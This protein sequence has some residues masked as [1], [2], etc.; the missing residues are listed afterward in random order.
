MKEKASRQDT[1]PKNSS[2]SG[3]RG[4]F[5]TLLRRSKI[6]VHSL[7]LVPLA[8]M[9]FSCMAISLMPGIALYRLESELAGHLPWVLQNFTLGLTL[10]LGYF[11]YGFSMIFLIPLACWILGA[12]PSSFKGPY[13]SFETAKWYVSNAFLYLVR[14]TFLELVTP[15]PI[16]ILFYRMM[17]MK[18]GRGT[19]INTTH[20]S[21]PAMIELGEKVTIGGSAVL[22]AHYGQA[23]YLVIAPLK[24]GD[25]ATIGLRAT[26]MGGVEIGAQAKILPN[27]VVLPKTKVPAGEI[28]GGVP[29]RRIDPRDLIQQ[30]Q[31]A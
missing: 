26:V 1:D 10:V 6:L 12:R 5:E 24:I 28:W 22:V 29:A 4:V 9:I 7:F 13:Y 18:I 20:I 15:T 25:G 3:A 16:N 11:G 30:P 19:Q 21:D 2:H 8:M 27:S 31:S 14:Y 23:G 17:G